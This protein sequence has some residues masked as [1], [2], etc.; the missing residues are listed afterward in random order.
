MNKELLTKN[1]AA[2]PKHVA[3]AAWRGTGGEHIYIKYKKFGSIFVVVV[4]PGS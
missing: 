2:P 1:M 4:V 3:N